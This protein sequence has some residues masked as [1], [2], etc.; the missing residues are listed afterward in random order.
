MFDRLAAHFRVRDQR[1][2]EEPAR[3][4]GIAGPGEPPAGA[5]RAETPR[6]RCPRGRDGQ[7]LRLCVINWS[8]SYGGR[9]RQL[10]IAG[11]GA[12]SVLSRR[13]F[14]GCW[15]PLVAAGPWASAL[16]MD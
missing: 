3:A 10:L 8:A 4:V 5:G 11:S 12:A 1:M 15:P 13:G 6:G 16:G 7:V 14:G 9:V 2:Y